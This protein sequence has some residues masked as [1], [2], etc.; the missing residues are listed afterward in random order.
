[1]SDFD[2]IVEKERKKLNPKVVKKEQPKLDPEPKTIKPVQYL[3]LVDGYTQEIWPT[4]FKFTPRKDDSVMSA[5]GRRLKIT[6]II[7]SKDGVVIELGRELGG[8]VGTSGDG[9]GKKGPLEY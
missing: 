3:L 2:K 7:H 4:S 8:A 6:G 5:N 9:V 1:M